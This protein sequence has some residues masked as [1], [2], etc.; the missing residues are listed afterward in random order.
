MRD[1][2]FLEELRQQQREQERMKE[3]DPKDRVIYTAH[4]VRV[5]VVDLVQ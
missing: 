1:I 2:Q 5:S 3:P 4:M